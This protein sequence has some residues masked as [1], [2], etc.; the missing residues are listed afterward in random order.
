MSGTSFDGVDAS[1]IETDG[2]NFIKHIKS[3]TIEYCKQ[4]KDIYHSQNLQ[5]F[6][7]LAKAIN[8]KHILSIKRVIKEACLNKNDIDIIGVHGQTLIHRPQERWSWQY[9][10]NDMLLKKFKKIVVSD[11]R[12]KDINYGGQ[13]APLVPIFHNALI[14]NKKNNSYPCLMI[15]IGGVT[16]VT[17]INTNNNFYG[18]D[19][20][21]GNGPLDKI[22]KERLSLDMDK[23]GKLALEGKVNIKIASEIKKKILKIDQNSYD[24]KELDLLCTTETGKL[25]T[26]DALATLCYLISDLIRT[27]IRKYKP[28]K[29]ILLGGGRKNLAIKSNLNKIF[30][31]TVSSA[32]EFGVD[33]DSIESQAFAYL[34]VRSL[35][36]LPYTFKE[37]TSVM[38]P[39]SGGVLH[40][41]I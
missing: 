28:K 7:T 20:G 12:L 14:K 39:L 23:E 33:G 26:S 9:I 25:N 40:N 17:V 31:E 24:R 35:L 1:I 15:N 2:E 32:E 6:Q 18:Y 8:N 22:C 41:Y 27:K 11:F 19:I 5:K 37:T 30:G 10:D 29:I 16:N 38:T 21:P 34:A 3:V 36:G 13:G 4:E